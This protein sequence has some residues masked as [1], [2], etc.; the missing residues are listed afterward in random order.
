MA[1]NATWMMA[2]G[3]MLGA[4]A[5]YAQEELELPKVRFEPSVQVLELEQGG[6]TVVKPD[7]TVEPGRCYK[8]YPYKTAFTVEPGVKLRLRFSDLTYAE[9]TGPAKVTPMA[10]EMFQKV[11]LDVQQGAIDFSVDT[12]A[13]AGQFTVLTPM[14][15]FASLQGTSQLYVGAIESGKVGENDFAFRTLSGSAVFCG[16]HNKMGGM[17]QANAFVSD[18]TCKQI[19]VKGLGST[20]IQSR[21][22]RLEGVSGEVK[23]ALPMGEIAGEPQQLDFALTPGAVVKITRAK[24]PASDHWVVSVLTLYANGKAQNYFCYVEGRGEGYAT[25]DLIGEVLPED[26]EED[27]EDADGE[28]EAGASDDASEDYGDDE[29]L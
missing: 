8:A 18:D 21:D 23:T 7:G 28:G 12:R 27:G 10:A 22:T 11:T 1:R 2:L 29:L 20:R 4:V 9:V 17:T 15:S 19:A 16:L 26:A 3:V 6:L 24:H 13:E 14:G 5:V 25:G